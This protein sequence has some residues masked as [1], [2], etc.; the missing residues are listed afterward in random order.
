MRHKDVDNIAGHQGLLP[1]P[2]WAP[3][4]T[5]S[6]ALLGVKRCERTVTTQSPQQER[7]G[8]PGWNW[9]T[10]QEKNPTPRTRFTV[11]A[12]HPAQAQP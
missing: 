8:P 2:A 12:G 4:V 10:A 3:S 1:R 11:G 5:A 6:A 9:V 7:H